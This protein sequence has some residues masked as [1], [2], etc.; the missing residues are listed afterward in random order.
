MTGRG[1]EEKEMG[2]PEGVLT[3]KISLWEGPETE[4]GSLI[5]TKERILEVLSKAMDESQCLWFDLVLHTAGQGSI[6]PFVNNVYIFGKREV[7]LCNLRKIV[8][9]IASKKKLKKEG[10]WIGGVWIGFDPFRRPK[11]E[12]FI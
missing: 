5:G 2:T 4:D 12:D 8:E 10:V 7:I 6:G 11:I 1:K 9:K 3:K